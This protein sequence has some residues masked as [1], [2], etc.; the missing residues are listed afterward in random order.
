MDKECI[1]E[2]IKL[3]I[4]RIMLIKMLFYVTSIIRY[5]NIISIK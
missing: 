4:Y 1:N 5:V 3:T 2:N